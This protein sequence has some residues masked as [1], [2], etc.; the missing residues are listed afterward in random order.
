MFG[1]RKLVSPIG[2]F[3]QLGPAAMRLRTHAHRT[4]TGLNTTPSNLD[5][6]DHE[7]FIML[8]RQT[9]FTCCLSLAIKVI[10]DDIRPCQRTTTG[11]GVAA[12]SFT[13]FCNV[14]M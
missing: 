5:L 13:T 4:Y 3:D 6:I 10:D 12:N 9:F 7:A 2:A 8:K 14:K 11:L 1:K